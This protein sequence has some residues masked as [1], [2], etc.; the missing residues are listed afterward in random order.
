MST[1]LRV[2]AA[3][4]VVFAVCWLLLVV[5]HAGGWLRFLTAVSIV[6]VAAIVLPKELSDDRLD[7]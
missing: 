4:C 2:V 5:A 3:A 7:D 6:A 1:A